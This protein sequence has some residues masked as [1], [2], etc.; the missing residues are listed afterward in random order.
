MWTAVHVVD[1]YNRA[2]EIENKLIDEGF[3]VKV[4]VFTKEGDTLLYEILA[5]ELEAE[6]VQL[7]L[8]DLGII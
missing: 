7:A 4:E 8:L 6:D 1:S 2:K 3:L 5:P